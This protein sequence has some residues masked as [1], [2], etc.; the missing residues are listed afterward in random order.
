MDSE[1]ISDTS[2]KAPCIIDTGA[3]GGALARPVNAIIVGFA[4]F[5]ALENGKRSQA[6][7]RYLTGLLAF[8]QENVHY[9]APQRRQ[10]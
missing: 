8:G 5:M 1:F 3:F 6:F 9:S 2:V 10:V 4:A 7:S